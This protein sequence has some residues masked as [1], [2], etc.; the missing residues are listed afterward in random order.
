MYHEVTIV[1]P[2]LPARKESYRKSPCSKSHWEYM[3]VSIWTQALYTSQQYSF[4]CWLPSGFFIVQSCLFSFSTPT[5]LFTWSQLPFH[6]PCLLEATILIYMICIFWFLCILAECVLF[7]M[8]AFWLNA[9]SCFVC[10]NTLFLKIPPYEHS[11]MWASK[12]WHLIV[13]RYLL[14]V[15]LPHFTYPLSQWWR[16]DFLPTPFHLNDYVNNIHT[17]MQYATFSL[18]MYI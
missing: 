11:C 10:L 3:A 17:F 8:H 18:G 5:I 7:C 9:I 16:A 13:A 12:L 1:I 14:G 15:H 6:F 2:I 4:H